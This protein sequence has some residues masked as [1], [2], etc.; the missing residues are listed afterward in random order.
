MQHLNTIDYVVE[1]YHLKLELVELKFPASDA[2]VLAK[3]EEKL[4]KGDIKLCFFDLV[5][6]GPG[7]KFPYKEITK[8]CKKYNAISC[9]DGAHSI[10]ML[11]IDLDELQAD[12]YITNLHK[13][14]YCPRGCALLYVDPKFH[15][16]IEPFPISHTY[17]GA[18]F[19]EKFLFVASNNYVSYLVVE[20]A[21]KFVNETCGGLENIRSY[22][23][24]LRKDAIEMFTKE[25]G[26]KVLENE[27]ET[28][29]TFMFNVFVDLKGKRLEYFKKN[30]SPEFFVEIRD[31]IYD[32]LIDGKHTYIQFGIYDEQLFVRFSCQIYNELSEYKVTYEWFTDALDQFFKSKSL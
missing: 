21:L 15:K 32:I 4:S 8:L 7:I 16:D 10:G 25:M 11:P 1:R 22:C 29:S 23:N 2:D 20:S 28:I 5:C 31:F 19:Y 17:K 6:S 14:L 27:E 3:F 13:W 26:L 30:A 9:I 12:F 24:G 18:K